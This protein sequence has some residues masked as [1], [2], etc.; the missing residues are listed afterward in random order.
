MI[1]L[2]GKQQQNNRGGTNH[3]QSLI[4]EA[5]RLAFCNIQTRTLSLLIISLFTSSFYL[6]QGFPQMS[7]LLV[8]LALS[9][10]EFLISFHWIHIFKV[11]AKCKITLATTFQ[12]GFVGRENY[13]TG[14]SCLAL[15]T[16]AVFVLFLCVYRFFS[17]VFS[18]L[19]C[20]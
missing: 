12:W 1:S 18:F 11:T 17:N 3:T 10:W 8:I 5:A 19:N 20:W 16:Q 4:W 9:S 2:S 15:V 13:F 7:G 14:I 6:F